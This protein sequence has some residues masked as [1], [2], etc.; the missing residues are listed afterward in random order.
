[1]EV[2]VSIGEYT[3]LGIGLHSEYSIVLYRITRFP[4]DIQA[5]LENIRTTISRAAPDAKET[6]RYQMPTFKLE[7]NLVLFTAYAFKRGSQW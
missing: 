4:I 1:M 5:I 2:S 7:G 3:R 6:I